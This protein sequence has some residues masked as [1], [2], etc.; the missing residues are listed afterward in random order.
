MDVILHGVLSR[1]TPSS[2]DLW[3]RNESC[4]RVDE[5]VRQGLFQYSGLRVLPH[6]A[7]ASG[8][9]S[10]SG[11]LDLTIEGF[12][13]L[14]SVCSRELSGSNSRLQSGLEGSNVCDLGKETHVE[15]LRLAEHQLWTNGVIS[16]RQIVTPSSIPVL[17]FRDAAHGTRCEL[18]VGNGCAVFKA[19]VLRQLTL[20]DPRFQQLV[21]LVRAWARRQEILDS[22]HGL[23]NYPSII[24]MVIFHLQT[25]PLPILPPICQLFG[26]AANVP[27]RQRPQHNGKIP[28]PELLQVSLEAVHRW[29]QRFRKNEET[30]PDLLT[31]FWNLYEGILGKW[32]SGHDPANRISTWS[33]KWRYSKWST[34][35]HVASI[36]D[37]FDATTN[38]AQYVTPQ[39]LSLIQH[40]FQEANKIIKRL[41]PYILSP[42]NSDELEALFG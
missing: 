42:L 13:T 32:A 11:H 15:F 1:E 6:G 10:P 37:P 31:S 19:K 8:L 2:L 39:G 5:C 41:Q 34:R 29:G 14:N 27:S 22:S 7:F 21:L 18:T 30:L 4:K 25:R 20:V 38:C 3:A 28:S 35:H 17:S 33:A 9:A 16:E 26:L 36:E 24:L 23:L 40:R 12:L